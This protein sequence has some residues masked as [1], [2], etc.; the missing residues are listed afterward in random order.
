MNLTHAVPELE[1]GELD[2]NVPEVLNSIDASTDILNKAPNVLAFLAEAI[3]ERE[4]ALADCKAKIILDNP[5]SKQDEKKSMFQQDVRA[6][7]LRVEIAKV[8]AMIEKWNL[9]VKAASKF[10]TN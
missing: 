4:E 2:F 9:A 3:A 8:E 5:E 10:Y 6:K 7:Q 1:Y